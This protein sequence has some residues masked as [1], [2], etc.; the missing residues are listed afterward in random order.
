MV[1]VFYRNGAVSAS[2]RAAR[3]LAIELA[4]AHEK[5]T[6]RVGAD[7]FTFLIV[8]SGTANGAV[9][10]PVIFRILLGEQ[11][12]GAIFQWT[13][14]CKVAN[15]FSRCSYFVNEFCRPDKPFDK[16][17]APA[18]LDFAAP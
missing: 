13:S 14:E 5:I 17:I 11:R 9:V 6:L 18:E 4:A 16:I 7:I 3:P 12:L 1:F 8:E 10:P 15:E 2:A